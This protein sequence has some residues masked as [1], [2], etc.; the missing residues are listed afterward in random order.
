M[1]CR[2]V[3]TERGPRCPPTWQIQGTSDLV[4]PANLRAQR[5]RT[6]RLKPGRRE[7]NFWMRRQGAKNRHQTTPTLA[8]TQ[9]REI[10]S[11]KSAQK[12]P[13]WRHVG[14]AWFV[15]TGWWAH[16]GSKRGTRC[17]RV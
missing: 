9:I 7:R 15:R 1:S 12:R 14:N 17:L 11:R 5:G 2:D 4:T 6:S 16:Q 8:E 13:I 10:S 3:A